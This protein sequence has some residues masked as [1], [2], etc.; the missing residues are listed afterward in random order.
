[1][2]HDF[3]GSNQEAIDEKPN[4]TGIFF[5]LSKS[6][7]VLNHKIL[8]SKVDASGIRGVANL[9]FKSYLPNWKQCFEVNDVGSAQQLSDCHTADL[10]EILH[11]VPQRSALGPILFLL[12]INDLP[13]NVHGAK[14]VLFASATNIEMKAENIDILNHNVNR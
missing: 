3:L 8:F 14:N 2:I 7:G 10:K 4:L 12:H 9:W 11:G 13:I 6:Q 5:E 1:V